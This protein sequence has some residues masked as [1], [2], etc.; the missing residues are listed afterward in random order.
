MNDCKLSVKINMAHFK[1]WMTSVLSVTET[2]TLLQG[3]GGCN[4]SGKINRLLRIP[5]I[6]LPKN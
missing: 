5:K 4:Y 6:G 3:M 2:D 1:E